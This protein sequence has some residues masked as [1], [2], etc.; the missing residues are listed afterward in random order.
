ME[1]RVIATAP[2]VFSSRQAQI[3]SFD[4]T[5]EDA[6]SKDMICGGRLEVLLE[7]INADIHTQ[8]LFEALYQ[9]LET[10]EKCLL[11][12]SPRSGR[13]GATRVGPGFWQW[14]T[15]QSSGRRVYPLTF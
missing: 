7:P 12:F 11:I 5:G 10:G 2:A 15:E 3:A 1:A 14:L 4:L 6:N 8:T 13:K 9:A